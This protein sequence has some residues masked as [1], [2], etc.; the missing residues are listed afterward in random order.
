[1]NPGNIMKSYITIAL[2]LTVPILAYAQT[3]VE[4]EVS[5]EWTREDSPYI[6]VDSS[7]KISLDFY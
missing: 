7:S 5:G 3:E 2:I 4:G 6:V 1:M